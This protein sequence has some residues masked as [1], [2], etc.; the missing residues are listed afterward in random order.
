MTLPVLKNIRVLSTKQI[1]LI[2][3]GGTVFIG[4]FLQV[5]E[6]QPEF[7]NTCHEMEFNYNTWAVSTHNDEADCLD[8][9]TEPG[10]KGYIDTRR[11]SITELI[12]HITGK[13]EVPI[14][15]GAR[16]KNPQCLKCHPDA[17]NITDI[18]VDARHDL[19]MESN[20]LC[21]DCHSRLVHTAVGEPKVIQ[22]NQCDDCHNSHDDFSIQ[23]KHILL[24]CS[25]CHPEGVYEA[26]LGLC[27]DCHVVPVDHVEGVYSNCEACHSDSGWDVIK[28]DHINISLKGGHFN[29]TCLDCHET[30]RYSGLSSGC[31]SC[32][33]LPEPH[34]TVDNQACV[35]CHT[36]NNWSPA[37]FG[38]SFYDLSGKHSRVSCND[39][40]IEGLYE[41]TSTLCEDCHVAPVDHVLD[42][43]E[44][45]DLCHTTDE[46]SVVLFDHEVFPLAEEHQ[47]VACLDCHGDKAYETA[48]SLCEDCHNAPIDHA[49]N[50][51]TECNLCHTTAGWTPAKFDH[52]SYPLT[53][54]HTEVFCSDCHAGGV[55]EGTPSECIDCH[56]EPTYHSGLPDCVQCHTDTSFTPSTYEHPRLEKHYP[57]GEERLDCVDCHRATYA[58]YSCKGSGCHS[59]NN[60]TDEDD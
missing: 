40:H 47:D 11:R 43:E 41:G 13:Y 56:A 20:V 37:E 4:A 50:I 19:H 6:A 34:I 5:I 9:H 24:R 55:F 23:G 58:D 18:T 32:H 26:V 60:P 7:C 28:F 57:R 46:W 12:A 15:T 25:E 39:C 16:V 8:C 1:L 21:A 14:Q 17:E 38:H 22:T 48:S 3:I 36:V 42:I 27:Q 45:C 54:A 35:E 59:T 2:I 31:E 51:D 30:Y 44:T 10:V 52:S 49:V 29:L 33:D 53:G